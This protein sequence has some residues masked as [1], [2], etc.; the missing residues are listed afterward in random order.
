MK[1]RIAALALLVLPVFS[2]CRSGVSVEE[3]VASISEADYLAKISIIAHDS[4]LGR[5]NLTPELVE[6]AEWIA[7]EFQ[8]Y[9]L[10]P[11]GDNG[12]FLQRYTIRRVK[13]DFQASSVQVTGTMSGSGK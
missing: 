9:G 11:G 2:A 3:A 12:S 1:K 13:P 10:K 7:A 6:T 5:A 8:R 4:M